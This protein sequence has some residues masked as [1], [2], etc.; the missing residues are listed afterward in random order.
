MLLK[1][2]ARNKIVV[3]GGNLDSHLTSLKRDLMSLGRTKMRPQLSNEVDKVDAS[4]F[5]VS[6]TI[7]VLNQLSMD[8]HNRNFLL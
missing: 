1:L 2:L 7:F 3:K 5:S 4:K 6:M 8:C